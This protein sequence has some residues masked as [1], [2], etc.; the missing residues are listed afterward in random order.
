MTPV[1]YIFSNG[2]ISELEFQ[3]FLEDIGADSESIIDA[4]PGITFRGDSTV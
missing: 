2:D 4:S 1:A 3:G